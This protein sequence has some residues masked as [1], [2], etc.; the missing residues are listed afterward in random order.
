MAEAAAFIGVA[1]LLPL[2]AGAFALGPH[3]AFVASIA[4]TL[5]VW[6]AAIV[7]LC[8]SLIVG[9]SP[10]A[11]VWLLM[12]GCTSWVGLNGGS[13]WLKY[14]SAPGDGHDNDVGDDPVE[15]PPPTDWDTFDDERA[16][17]ERRPVGAT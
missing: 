1:A 9:A 14:R 3:W 15:P 11:A 6:A 13:A 4:C 2:C 5:G 12:A 17:W 16:R 10:D 7:V 8:V